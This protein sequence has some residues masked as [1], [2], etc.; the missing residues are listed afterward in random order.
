M[1]NDEINGAEAILRTLSDN[2][3]RTVFGNP[4][5]SE[6]HFVA[7]LDDHPEIRGVL[8]L[9]EGVAT[10][11]ADGYA[12]MTGRPA[13]TLLHLGPGL[14]NG[15]ANLHNARRAGSAVLNIVGDHA[16]DHKPL[17]A[18]LES[19]I[20]AVAASVSAWVHRPA[21]PSTVGRDVAAA[22]AAT[23][24]G[25]DE[26]HAT[27]TS[28]RI[29]TLIVPADVSWSPGGA[30][31][32]A[33]PPRAVPDRPAA[34]DTVTK[35]L[36][37]DEP[38]ALLL[39][40][41]AL[42]DDGLRA[43]D[44]IAQVTGARLFCPTWPA[45]L[46]RGAGMP[47]VTPLAYRS[48]DVRTQFAGVRHVV[49]AGA[50]TPVASF[51]Y[52]GRDGILIP[53]EV[54]AHV[55]APE[56]V[57]VADALREIAD[58][59][60]P[61]TVAR[62]SAAGVPVVPEGDLD[63]ANWAPAIASLLPENAIVCDES[64]TAGMATV[65]AAFA[66]APA[67]DVLGL[68]GLAVGQGL[69]LAAGAALACPRRPVIC[70]EADGSAIYTISALWTYARENLDITVVVL[71]NRSY[72]ILRSELDRVGANQDAGAARRMLDLTRPDLD[73]VA[74]STGLGVPASRARTVREL[75][76]QFAAAVADPG[77]HLIEAVIV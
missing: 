5:T 25:P 37:G 27:G 68:T 24:D 11:A 20:D 57:P 16:I 74:L 49:L 7:A 32:P 35:L 12:R 42:T 53:A 72:A 31:A 63:A 60:A 62:G 69:P 58:D 65:P 45:R 64:I 33:R 40:G 17:D 54:T 21:R 71:N 9:F 47:G 75:R 59:L 6:M 38:V 4:G 22:I 52:P 73:F 26:E 51:A 48:E 56:L 43:A 77:P 10:G 15:L 44:R 41:D 8:C 1:V 66:G 34:V 55:L 46:R 70:L 50:R 23:L 36:A 28:G 39:D 61:G 76:E 67:H 13:A 30:A 29:A 2:G 19:D 18:L 3:V 14:G